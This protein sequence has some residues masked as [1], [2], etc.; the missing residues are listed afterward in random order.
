MENPKFKT[1]STYD[2]IAQHIRTFTNAYNNP[3]DEYLMRLKRPKKDDD[4][5]ETK[6]HLPIDKLD[7]I[8]R[9]LYQSIMN[10]I[11][12]ENQPDWYKI[13]LLFIA[14]T[15]ARVNEAVNFIKGATVRPNT[16]K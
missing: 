6:P 2:G 10:A 13:G 5:E 15:G 14:D 3:L 12:C 11:Q 9:M 1:K 7:T 8:R 16:A 4:Q